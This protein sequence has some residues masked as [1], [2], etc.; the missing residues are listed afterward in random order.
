MLVVWT[1]QNHGK[2]ADTIA[3][4]GGSPLRRSGAEPKRLSRSTRNLILALPACVPGRAAGAHRGG[5]ARPV[6]TQ[7]HTT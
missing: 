5:R 3:E 1:A 7:E 2:K 4:S 6:A